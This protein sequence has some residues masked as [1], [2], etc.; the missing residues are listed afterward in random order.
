MKKLQ[1]LPILLIVPLILPAQSLTNIKIQMAG[2][3]IIINYDLES[4]NTDYNFS[5]DIYSS[6][7]N[8]AEPLK[9]VSGDVGPDVK[10]GTGKKITWS[11]REE[12]GDIE[13]KIALEIR[14]RFFIPFLTLLKPVQHAK[15][16]RSK[17]YNIEWSGGASSDI[18]IDLYEN[19]QRMQT[20]TTAQNTGVFR[21]NVPSALKP[22]KNYQLLLSDS[23]NEEDQV[24]SEAFSVTHKIP[25]LVKGAAV[26]ALGAIIYFLIPTSEESIPD[27]PAV[28]DN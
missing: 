26:V 3:Q 7:N 18:R 20:I 15:W 8:Y 2:D 1:L 24:Y 23:R 22:G 14:A 17:I 16:K 4:V 11:A 5:V 27:P 12:L 6:H 21:W 25:T 9:Q 10:L 28:P 19:S 13:A